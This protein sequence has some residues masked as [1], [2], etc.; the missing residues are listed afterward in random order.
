M[1]GM[2]RSTPSIIVALLLSL[3]LAACG[4]GTAVAPDAQTPT[5][6]STVDAD[7]TRRA[8]ADPD[9]GGPDVAPR[10]DDSDAAPAADLP[11]PIEAG[12]DAPAP[13]DNDSAAVADAPDQVLGE[14]TAD[15]AP[16][17]PGVGPEV[18]EPDATDAS[19]STDPA[20]PADA[21]DAADVPPPC[22]P[23][24]CDDGDPCTEDLCDDAAEGG[25]AHAWLTSCGEVGCADGVDLDQDG[26][27][28]CQDSDC[29]GFDGCEEPTE[30]V[31]DDHL[32]DDG[33]G[34][35]DC[36]D[37][38]CDG[39]AGCEPG[40][41]ATCDDGFD[42]DADGLFD[43]ADPDCDG[44]G[45]CQPLGEAACGDG[46]DNDADGHTD[47]ADPDCDGLAG[48]EPGGEVSCDDD[49][50]ND[51]DGDAD[52]HDP[53]CDGIAGCE[54]PAESTCGDGQDNDADGLAD[55][56]DPDCDGAA[57]CEHGQEHTCG[58]G[59]DNDADGATDCQ[60]AD[61]DGMGL[62]QPTGEADCDDGADNDADGD[63]DCEDEDCHGLGACEYGSEQTCGDGQ[64]NDADGLADC[65]DA[66]CDG[67]GACEHGA[68]ETCDDG[69][70]NDA[71]GFTDCEEPECDDVGYCEH[72]AEQTCGGGVDNDADGLTDC[73][74]PDCD[75]A[76]GCEY[77]VEQT[78]DDDKD[79]DV[80]GLSD[81]ADDDCQGV[82]GCE[83]AGET[84]CDDDE[85][86][87][88]DGLTDC[89]DADCHGLDSCELGAETSCADL[90]DNDAD[91]ATDCADPDCDGVGSCE[92]GAEASCADDIDNDADDHT[93][94][95][96]FDCDLVGPCEFGVEESCHDGVDNDGDGA[97]DCADFHC[98][99]CAGVCCGP[100]LVCHLDACKPAC[101]SGVWCGAA[102]DECC[103]AGQACLAATCV[104]PGAEC[105]LNED[106]PDGEVCEPVLGQCVP[107]GLVEPC[108]FVPEVGAF[109]PVLGCRWTP[110][111]GGPTPDRDNVV[112]NPVVANLTDDNGDGLTDRD[113]VPDI[114]FTA[115]DH[116][117]GGC[118]DEPAT[119]WII[120]GQCNPDGTM[121][122][123]GAMP[124]PDLDESGGL[125]VG[126]LTGDGV[127]EVVGM[128]LLG[129]TIAYERLAPD[130]SAW[131]MLWEQPDYPAWGVHTVGATQPSLAD[132]DGDGY[133][134]VVVGN[135]A[136]S[137]LDGGL[138][139]DGVVTSGGAGGV[140]NNA[141]L[142]PVST[143]ADIDLDGAPEV[144]AGNTVY[145]PDG[146]VEWTYG[147]TSDGGT[148][149]GSLPCD[150][151]AA[152]G[153]FDDDDEGEVVLV[154]QGEIFILH[155][156]GTLLLKIP[157]PWIDCVKGG[158]QANESGPPTI[159]DFDGDGFAEIGTAGA[160]YYVVADLQC[161]GDPL[162]ADC[163]APWIRWNTPNQDCSSRATASSVFDFEGDGK[164]E[165]VYAD[166]TSFR[167]L[168]GA[169]GA[170]LYVDETH[171]SNTRVEMPVIADVD[172]DGSAEIV[173][174][175]N[176]N[177][178]GTP[179]I[180]VWRDAEDTWVRSRRIWNQHAY[181]I[182]NVSE[183]GIVPAHEA[184]NWLDSRYNSFRQNIQPTGLFDAPDLHLAG[185]ATACGELLQVAV[186]V[187]NEG[188]LGVPAGV[189]VELTLTLFDGSELAF[190]NQVTQA[191]ILPGQCV[192]V[193]F[194]VP[195]PEAA[196]YGLPF[197]AA[198]VIDHDGTVNGAF[199]ECDE[200][201]N[202][203][204]VWSACPY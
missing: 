16:D 75:G 157:I 46:K 33:D 73:H 22:D 182:T 24:A 8:A 86:N 135:V 83:P 137:G 194:S 124:S 201:D 129:G 60:D 28:D 27:T 82:A 20:D 136:L 161:T 101:A 110:P 122:T 64:D 139:W 57:G 70:D 4:S 10:S 15:A 198:V 112:M 95:A 121:T 89:A 159:A 7:T 172:N 39:L 5:D 37:P 17:V 97:S 173:I 195:L 62:C 152:V 98:A 153:D 188:A 160:D 13:L 180:E 40:G 190:G 34:L 147:F 164:A 119:L 118:C 41:E 114:A 204:T 141:F 200:D 179:G 104:A 148:C 138:L 21:A 29:W 51:A 69:I 111:P 58:D 199:N 178:G 94:C 96:D 174:P 67:V 183:D 109:E 26:L 99:T 130:G 177:G 84:T 74:D 9:G 144:I 85:D 116:A 87:D 55:C 102:G 145:G 150:G 79:N 186:C 155:H 56:H 158:I 3:A 149:Q 134:E 72:G 203:D 197:T 168:D 176:Q 81:C 192:D 45:A 25:C 154:R 77:G 38:D 125:A 65:E 103:A 100:G 66:D 31:C 175:E 18:G 193:V 30:A 127:P 12:P 140:G 19:D 80:D 88:A 71:D 181:H 91:G 106:C 68:E 32:D 35:F 93:D 53:D 52:C 163:V 185:L 165:V 133:P 6:L 59:E 107:E 1:V 131:G 2:A 108:E 128:L 78:C 43:C 42:N 54:H 115:W 189:L 105:E 170:E 191:P 49:Q 156:D 23:S 126:D 63:A 120:S 92:A 117:L 11:A 44:E 169:T 36:H 166:E 202:A 90:S 123:L 196:E 187:G 184:P 162:P 47:C 171:G 143:V 48:C 14:A 167:I 113:D 61:C 146:T 142:G 151:Y 132:L 50:D 76:A